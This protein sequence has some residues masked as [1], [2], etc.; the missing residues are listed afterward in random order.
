MNYDCMITYF[1][2]NTRGKGV[3]IMSFPSFFVGK[4]QTAFAQLCKS[5]NNH[6]I[7]DRND[8][9]AGDSGETSHRHAGEL[10]QG[11]TA[12]V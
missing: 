10:R 6:G 2:L 1:V 12:E 5:K 3:A 7:F 11:R 4:P 9:Q 8:E